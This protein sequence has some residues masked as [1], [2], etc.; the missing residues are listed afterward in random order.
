MLILS[1]GP[2]NISER[3]RRALTKPDIGHREAEFSTLLVDTKSLLLDV[4]GVPQGYACAVLSGSGT[5]AIEATIT[6]L[7]DVTS[8]VLI[9]SNGVYGER[10]AQIAQIYGVPHTLENFEW[11]LPLPLDRVEAL[12]GATPHDTVYLIHHETTT[13]VLN[14]LRDVAE[15]ARRHHKWVL[16][17]AVSSVAGEELDLSG[18]GVDLITGSANKCIRGV[19]GVSFV[20]L[21]HNLMEAISKRRQVAFSTDLVTTLSKE[22]EGETPFTPP[23]QTMYALREAL[24]EL[25]EDGVQNRI[26]G[27]RSIAKTLRDGLSSLELNF[28]V[29]RERLSNT[30]TSVMLPEGLTYP[31][32]H[33]PLKD[34]GYVIYKSQGHLSKTTFRLGTVGIISQDEIHGFLDTLGQVLRR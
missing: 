17:D 16:V 24:L 28:L 34:L 23:I 30:M 8:G 9:L 25:A 19:P 11:T 1:P 29:P 14:P 5:T 31:T 6:S 21:S 2:A 20:V 10:A 4:F 15:I 13:G 27:Y 12:I 22:D 32:L 18:W 7:C 26:A 33:D 3:V